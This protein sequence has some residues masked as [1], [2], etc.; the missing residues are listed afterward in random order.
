MKSYGTYNPPETVALEF[1]R[2]AVPTVRELPRAPVPGEMV[3]LE[4]DMPMP[5][6]SAPWMSRG[7]YA[8][9]GSKWNRLND[10]GRQRRSGLIGSQE[11]EIENVGSALVL[12]T[13]TDGYNISTAHIMPSNQKATITGTATMWLDAVTLDMTG[14]GYVWLSVF[15]NKMLVTVTLEYIEVGKPRSVALSFVDIPGDNK[16]QTYTI[17]IDTDLKGYL[18]INKSDRFTF[19]GISHTAFIVAEN[20]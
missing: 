19:E 16:E 17:R 6:N 9:D 13:V 10:G 3:N 18:Y 7:T 2:M 15:R 5:T 20:I 14:S 12:P 11:F 8:F 4:V 1:K